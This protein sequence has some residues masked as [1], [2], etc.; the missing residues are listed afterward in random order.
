MADKM[1]GTWQGAVVPSAT[2]IV[3]QM[4]GAPLPC[5]V[6]LAS[7]A[8]GRLIEL[9]SDGGVNYYTPALSVST[10]PMALLNVVNPVSHVRITGA[11]NDTW[12][13]R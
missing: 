11:T 9:S 7:A 5:A 13:I 4:I 1:G 8:G 10:V 2:P 6:T 12:S 3:V